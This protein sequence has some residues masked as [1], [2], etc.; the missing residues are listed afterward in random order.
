MGPNTCGYW[1]ARV[2][3]TWSPCLSQALLIAC[4]NLTDSVRCASVAF[5]IRTSR[6]VSW[7]LP[8]LPANTSAGVEPEL[9][10][11]LL[12]PFIYNTLL[13][14]HPIRSGASFR[15]RP[16]GQR[17]RPCG[18]T[19]EQDGPVRSHAVALTALIHPGGNRVLSVEIGRSGGRDGNWGRQ[20]FCAPIETA[21]DHPSQDAR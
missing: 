8:R 2:S 13:L 11:I 20:P 4:R 10:A 18:P 21:V 7:R 6:K 9:G 3:S 17:A 15:R 1:V 16:N 14:P 5:G 12:P 19:C